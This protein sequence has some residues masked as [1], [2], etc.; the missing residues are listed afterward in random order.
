MKRILK[1]ILPN[2]II[3]LAAK[4]K[5][6]YFSRRR[7]K[8]AV[9]KGE[10]D[11]VLQCCIAYNK[12]GG[13]C[14]PLSSYYRPASQSILSGKVYEANTID[15]LI[16]NC[17]NGDIIHAGAFFGDFIPALSKFLAPNAKVWVFEPNSE[18][19]LCAFITTKINRLNNV[20]LKNAGLG[21]TQGSASMRIKN[22]DGRTL[23][24]TSRIISEK[25][26]NN[27]QYSE[28]VEIVSI[29]AVIPTD[30]NISIL[31]LDVEGYEKEALMGALQTIKRC[32]PIIVLENLP[33]ENW[34][35]ENILKLGYRISG[36]AENNKILTIK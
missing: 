33:E 1:K 12:F 4:V 16:S 6:K 35:K 9:F 2:S 8:I 7:P 19:Y 5:E 11:S 3:V 23:G 29:D 36:K 30:R 27:S 17:R 13:Y 28:I 18:N 10:N 24:G 20:E 15:F 26:G 21:R 14:V 31:Q 25:D 34:L 32:K 22:S